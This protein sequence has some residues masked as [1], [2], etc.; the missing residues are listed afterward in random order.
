MVPIPFV[1]FEVRTVHNSVALTIAEPPV[2]TSVRLALKARG[3]SEQSQS[4]SYYWFP[5]RGNHSYYR[6][7]YTLG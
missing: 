5:F 2:L 3:E 6:V 1:M 7:F 4:P